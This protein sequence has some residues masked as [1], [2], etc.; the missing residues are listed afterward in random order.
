MSKAKTKNL[1]TG[2]ERPERA[3][4]ENDRRSFSEDDMKKYSSEFAPRACLLPLFS[5]SQLLFIGEISRPQA[6]DS[7]I[8]ASASFSHIY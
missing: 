2:M 7:V 1:Q 6:T 3:Q 4:G 8:K 5:C